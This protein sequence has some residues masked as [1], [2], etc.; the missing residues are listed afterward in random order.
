MVPKGYESQQVERFLASDTKAPSEEAQI[1]ALQDKDCDT[2]PFPVGEGGRIESI[3][4]GYDTITNGSG[5][6]NNGEAIVTPFRS[7]G[8]EY[9]PSWRS[10]LPLSY[11]PT[12]F[13]SLR[14]AAYGC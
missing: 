5:S 7:V 8:F 1:T 9:Q 13:K 11:Q 6:L 3:T 14:G 4:S 2:W 12:I 10:M